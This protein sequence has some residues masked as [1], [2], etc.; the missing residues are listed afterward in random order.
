MG[1][2]HAKRDFHHAM[3]HSLDNDSN[4]TSDAAY[5]LFERLACCSDEAFTTAVDSFPESS[6]SIT[7]S[8]NI[9]D[10]TVHPALGLGPCRFIVR[11]DQRQQCLKSIVTG[12]SSL[13]GKLLLTLPC[14]EVVKNESLEF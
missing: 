13:G 9:D 6:P 8:A 7:S 2:L 3:L 10:V 14:P 1:V 12:V 5:E 4:V 11:S